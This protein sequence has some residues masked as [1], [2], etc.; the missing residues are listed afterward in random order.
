MKKESSLY[1]LKRIKIIQEL[2]KN[3]NS[4]I[5]KSKNIDSKEINELKSSGCPCDMILI[6]NELGQFT[7]SQNDILITNFWKPSTL[8]KSSK[9]ETSFYCSLLS[10]VHNIAENL[11]FFCGI[12]KGRS[13]LL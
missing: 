6:L 7:L 11:L 4:I 2:I 10:E 8:Q 9:M 3:N 13:V 5:L 1:L 12:F